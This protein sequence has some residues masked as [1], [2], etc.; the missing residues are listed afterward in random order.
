MKTFLVT[1]ASR[2]IGNAIV[3]GLAQPG[4]RAILNDLELGAELAALALSLRAQGVEVV[5]ALGDV[6]AAATA[7][8]AFAG[9]ERLD[10]LVN[11]AGILEESPITDMSL[12]QWDRTLQVHLYGAFHFCK[13][14]A[15]LMK[16]QGSG[17]IVNIASDLGQLGCAN[18]CHYSAAKGALIALSKSLARELAPFGIRVNGV[19]P[20]G[21]LTPM[22]ERLGP[23]YIRE[24]AARYPLQRLGTAEEIAA[25]V[26]FLASPQASFMTGQIL[27]VNGGGVMNG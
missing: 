26:V 12:A 14:A 3:R 10:V 25:A 11:N 19:A 5:F 18:L 27:G 23:D 13:A 24:E 17:V 20:G 9:L 8:A 16:T 6:A 7:E 2:G 22:V 1:G 21:A 4:D 15:I